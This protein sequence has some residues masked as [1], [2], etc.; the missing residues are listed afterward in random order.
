MTTRNQFSLSVR[1]KRI[2]TDLYTPLIQ[3]WMVVGWPLQVGCSL[4]IAG[5]GF[6]IRILPSTQ[7]VSFSLPGV[8]CAWYRMNRHWNL[9]RANRG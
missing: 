2:L 7:I 1:P 4:S 9:V 8:Y 3:C 5:F 6:T